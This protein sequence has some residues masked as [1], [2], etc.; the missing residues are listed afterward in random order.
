MQNNCEKFNLPFEVLIQGPSGNRFVRSLMSADESA[1]KLEEPTD[2]KVR[3]SISIYQPSENNER[4]AREAEK[5]IEEA[6]KVAEE[7]PELVA[8]STTEVAQQSERKSDT[9]SKREITL[10]SLGER[11]LMKRDTDEIANDPAADIVNPSAKPATTTEPNVGSILL[12]GLIA[13]KLLGLKA[14]IQ[15]AKLAT[16]ATIPAKI[17]AAKAALIG[18]FGLVSP[19]LVSSTIKSYSHHI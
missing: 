3:S 1:S 10:E 18:K 9:Q 7:A 12:P 4:I 15:A 14:R 17:A 5:L 6:E 2:S 19:I 8:T 13:P 11:E 16:A